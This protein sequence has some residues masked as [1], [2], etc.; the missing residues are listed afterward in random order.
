[1][2]NSTDNTSSTSAGSN[3]SRNP[4]FTSHFIR[5]AAMNTFSSNLHT[6][7][8]VY[9]ITLLLIINTKEKRLVKEKKVRKRKRG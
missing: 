7:N 6:N 3:I 8:F 9:R 5:T 4:H 2:V 1:M